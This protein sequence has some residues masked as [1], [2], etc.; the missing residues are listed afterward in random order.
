MAGHEPR[1]ANRPAAILLDILEAKFG[2]VPVRARKRVEQASLV[3]LV[4]CVLRLLEAA[5]L[6]EA[7]GPMRAPNAARRAPRARG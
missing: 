7:L 3:Q 6:D 1:I 2:P 5:T 4:E